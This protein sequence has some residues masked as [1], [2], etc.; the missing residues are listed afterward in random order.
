[1]GSGLSAQTPAYKLPWEDMSTQQHDAARICGWTESKWDDDLPVPIDEKHWCDLCPAQRNALSILGYEQQSWD[2]DSSDS[3]SDDDPDNARYFP[4][5]T[6]YLKATVIDPEARLFAEEIMAADVIQGRF[7]KHCWLLCVMASLAHQY[8]DHLRSLIKPTSDG[9]FTVRLFS[10]KSCEWVQIAVDSRLHVDTNFAYS[11]LMLCQL[12]KQKALWPLILQK[13]VGKHVGGY[14][15][16]D[17]GDPVF[18]LGMLTGSSKLYWLEPIDETNPKGQ[19][20]MYMARP[21]VT[22]DP[23]DYSWD[24]HYETEEER[25]FE[26]CELFDVLVELKD[27]GGWTLCANTSDETHSIYI[28]ELAGGRV[29]LCDQADASPNMTLCVCCNLCGYDPEP[30]WLDMDQ[31]ATEYTISLAN[32]TP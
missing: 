15:K 18:G 31:F 25:S 20:A 23:Q 3:D 12:G 22:D 14:K 26:C 1:M 2:D 13:A 10:F 28:L 8:P 30:F 7:S 32:W 4:G 21:F 6:H 27:K 19:W 9:C 17:G 11:T 5:A 16:L 24:E 29:M